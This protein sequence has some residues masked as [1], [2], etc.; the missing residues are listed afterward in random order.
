[1]LM[2]GIIAPVRETKIYK[3][4]RVGERERARYNQVL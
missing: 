4:V 3:V 1:M 2:Y